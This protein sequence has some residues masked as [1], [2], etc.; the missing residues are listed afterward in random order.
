MNIAEI[1]EK[2]PN[3]ISINTLHKQVHRYNGPEYSR[4]YK[5]SYCVMGACLLA[6]GIDI[7]FPTPTDIQQHLYI[8]AFDAMEI[9][10]ANDMENFELAWAL[11]A[12]ALNVTE[13]P[14]ETPE[15][16]TSAEREPELVT[17]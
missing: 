7:H 12:A 1:R 16:E 13:T 17:A 10:A 4:F 14:V 15:E 8:G 2:Y 9:M 5:R 11:A 3:P 6:E